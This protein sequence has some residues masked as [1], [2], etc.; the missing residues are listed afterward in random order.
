MSVFE[1]VK[2]IITDV[3]AVKETEVSAE[4]SL[5]N[6]LGTD[7]LDYVALLQEFEAEF[8]IQIPDEDAIK[9]KTVED[10]VKYIER[11]VNNKG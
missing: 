2:K 3:M 10:T 4:T 9:L 1:R 8:N 5:A 7:S 11:K 6:D